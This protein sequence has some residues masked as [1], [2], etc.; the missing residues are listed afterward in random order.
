MRADLF[1]SKELGI[2]SVFTCGNAE[3]KELE[4]SHTTPV[5]PSAVT[6]KMQALLNCQGEGHAL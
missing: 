3:L 6:H 1:G 5:A 2:S 4:L